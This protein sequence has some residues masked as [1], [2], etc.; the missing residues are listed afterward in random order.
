[1][2]TI[3]KYSL[4]PTTEVDIPSGSV[5]LDIQSQFGEP[6]MWVLVDTS[7]KMEKRV[8][9]TYGTG[10][11]I[12]GDPGKYLGTFQISGGTL[13]FHVFEDTSAARP[14]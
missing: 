2:K 1:M 3:W 10:H 6:Q 11:K 5:I 4:K 8:F 13:V 9:N 7:E 12:E 14:L